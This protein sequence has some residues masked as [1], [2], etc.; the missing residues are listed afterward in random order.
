MGKDS[1]RKRK[2]TLFAQHPYCCYCGRELVYYKTGS[3]EQLPGNFAT[4][5]HVNTRNGGHRP[6][7][8][9]R[10][11]ACFDCNQDKGAQDMRA[12][13][14]TERPMTVNYP[15]PLTERIGELVP[16]LNSTVGENDRVRTA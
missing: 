14:N 12:Y 15:W 4:L 6:L 10:K 2:I 13:Y 1:R 9:E 3:G 7:Q 11:L 16:E 5:E 8:G